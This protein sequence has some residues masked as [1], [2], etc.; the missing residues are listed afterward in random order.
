MPILIVQGNK[1]IIIAV[2]N[3]L[4]ERYDCVIRPF[5]FLSYQFLWLIA[6]SMGDAGK[7]YNETIL[8]H[9]IYKNELSKGK[10]DLKYFVDSKFLRSTLAK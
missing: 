9:Y 3:W 6:I 8:Y 10:M 4:T 1:S 7:L 5:E 2:H